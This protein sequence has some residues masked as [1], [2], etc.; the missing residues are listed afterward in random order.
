MSL[1]NII[2]DRGPEWGLEIIIFP[3]IYIWFLCTKHDKWTLRNIQIIFKNPCY[4]PF[5]GRQHTEHFTSH[6]LTLRLVIMAI[7]VLQQTGCYQIHFSSR[8]CHRLPLTQHLLANT[9]SHHHCF[10]CLCHP[11]CSHSFL[12]IIPPGYC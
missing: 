5:K 6:H 9:V 1:K 8:P 4:D 11:G 12:S 10:H 2:S 3:H 7:T